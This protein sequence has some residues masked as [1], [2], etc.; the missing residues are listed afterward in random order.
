MG[1]GDA[2]EGKGKGRKS[3]YANANANIN[4]DDS[5]SIVRKKAVSDDDEF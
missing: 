5:P 3:K 4:V 2:R 1:Y